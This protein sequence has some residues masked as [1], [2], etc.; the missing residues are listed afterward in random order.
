MRYIVKLGNQRVPV[1]G[2]AEPAGLYHLGA[3]VPEDKYSR[4]VW[5]DKDGT[6]QKLEFVHRYLVT[7][8]VVNN[9]LSPRIEVMQ[10]TSRPLHPIQR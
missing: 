10:L 6:N 4:L 1:V 9:P 2:A 7:E 8:K 3:E 5:S